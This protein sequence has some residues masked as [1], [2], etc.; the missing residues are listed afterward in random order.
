MKHT[1]SYRHGTTRVWRLYPRD[2]TGCWWPASVLPCTAK[3][4]HQ[5]SDKALGDREG[6]V[7]RPCHD[8]TFLAISLEAACM[9]HQRIAPALGKSVPRDVLAAGHLILGKS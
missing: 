9:H 3:M 4:T 6:S 7:K 8:E 2:I 5:S 1:V